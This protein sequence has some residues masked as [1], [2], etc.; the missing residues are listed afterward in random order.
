MTP[1][2]DDFKPKD[3]P[4][5]GSYDNQHKSFGIDSRKITMSGRP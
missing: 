5:P 3:V 2:K 4:G 1:R